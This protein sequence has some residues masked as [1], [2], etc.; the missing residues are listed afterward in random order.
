MESSLK[1]ASRLLQDV[2][3]T[4]KTNQDKSNITSEVLSILRSRGED[5]ASV[6]RVYFRTIDVWLPIISPAECLKRLET[7][8]TIYNN[9]LACLILC[10]HL[11]TQS[12]DTSEN[13]S[14]IQTILYFQAKTL[15]SAFTSTGNWAMDIIQAGVLI[16]LYEQGHDMADAAQLTLA[17]C[18][19]SAIRVK[20]SLRSGVTVQNTEFGRLWWG[21][22]ILDR[23]MN[24]TLLTEEIYLLSGSSSDGMP[25][26]ELP[27]D[28]EAHTYLLSPVSTRTASGI[29]AASQPTTRLGPFCRAAEAAHLLGKVLGLVAQSA[30][31][32]EMNQHQSHKLDSSLQALAMTLLQQAVNGWEECCGAM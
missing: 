14:E 7:L 22:L 20:A 2:S 10:M 19:R 16:S 5:P 1:I 31:S 6:A 15:Y 23:H 13:V 30:S 8:T 18:V 3:V 28:D 4:S 32:G 9:E 24:Q 27:T 21:I 17:A 25:W 12:S 29:S 26:M 11:V